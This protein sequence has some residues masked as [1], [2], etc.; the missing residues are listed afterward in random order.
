MSLKQEIETWV[1][2]LAAYDHNEFESAQRCF[3]QI[4]DTSKILFNMGVIHAT[5]GE[6]GLAVDCYQR[7]VQ[8]D[9]YLAVSY[10]QQGVSNFLMGDFEEALANFN[11][12]LLYLRGNNNIDYEQLGLKFK[13]YSCEVLFNRGLCYIYLQQKDAGMQDLSFAAREKVVPDHGV[14]DEAIREQAEGYT[15]FSIPVGVIYRP[16]EAK[17]KNLKTKDYLG[18]ARL[19]AAQDRQNVDPRRQAAMAALA[20]DDRPGEKLSYAALNLVR[21]DLRSRSGRQQ[22]EP[23]LNRN[24]F[25]PTPP[26]EL[27]RPESSHEQRKSSET[28]SSSP[29]KSQA[30]R[31]AAK[32]LRLELGAAAFEQRSG[33]AE[34]PRLGNKRA[35]SER[36]AMRRETSSSSSRNPD[37]APRHP[38]PSSSTASRYDHTPELRI[39]DDPIEAYSQKTYAPQQKPTHQRTRSSAY[40][41]PHLPIS[42]E[43]EDDDEEQDFSNEPLA[44]EIIPPNH[45]AHRRHPSH[46]HS[47]SRRPTGPGPDLR[48]IRI[49]VHAEDMRYIMTNPS[50]PFHELV[51]QIRRKFSLT[52][53]FKLKIKDEEGDLVTLGDGEDW[54]M[55]V[56][57]CR[58]AVAMAGGREGEGMGRVEVW[59]QEV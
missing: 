32:P 43:D 20:L 41:S 3:L 55:V 53:K 49:K 35:A 8:L 29:T 16:N 51:E 21:P 19:V 48:T 9:Q 36:P 52:G 42:E 30:A 39:E 7:A 59:V 1:A 14:I 56:Q 18:K 17:V 26:P 31:T 11:D 57:G 28:S 4:A 38:K 46:S 12:T 54:E 22:S 33:G 15:V 45:T 47:H 50:I 2:A 5:L 40:K 44:F 58:T 10:F 13:L 27:E 34:K 23:P 37:P 6:H 24:M 25:P